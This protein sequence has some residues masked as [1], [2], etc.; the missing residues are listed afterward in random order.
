MQSSQAEVVLACHL[1]RQ[2]PQRRRRLGDM[3]NPL[4]DGQRYAKCGSNPINERVPT[5]VLTQSELIWRFNTIADEV[6]RTICGEIGDEFVAMWANH[7]DRCIRGSCHRHRRQHHP[8]PLL[9]PLFRNQL[10]HSTGRHQKISVAGRPD[11]LP[12]KKHQEPVGAL[13][14]RDLF[15]EL[16][17]HPSV[18]HHIARPHEPV[19]RPPAQ[20]TLLR[21]KDRQEHFVRPSRHIPRSFS[22]AEAREP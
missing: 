21:R 15:P 6:V 8:W 5:R 19:T 22:C 12:V 1:C 3:G 16:P 7:I 11:L 4:C 13:I 17:R 14:D 18:I 9:P 2:D 10:S 20:S